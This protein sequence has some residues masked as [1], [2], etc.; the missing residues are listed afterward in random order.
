MWLVFLAHFAPKCY[1]YITLP[2]S[3]KHNSTSAV[4]VGKSGSPQIT[5]YLTS[6]STT[7]TRRDSLLK[8]PVTPL[9]L[10]YLALLL[11]SPTDTCLVL[12]LRLSYFLCAITHENNTKP[13]NFSERFPVVPLS[14]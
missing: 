6:T 13:L 5:A 2:I 4:P 3:S 1:K 9:S 12:S 8:L 10:L 14:S 7:F 11:S